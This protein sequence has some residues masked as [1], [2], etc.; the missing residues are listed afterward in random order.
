[1]AFI[2]VKFPGGS[3]VD[4]HM[5]NYIVPTD[6]PVYAGGEGS[7]P[8]PFELFLASIATCAGIYALG[9]CQSKG[10]DT[11]GLAL[12]MDVTKNPE[13]NMIGK[14]SLNLTLPNGFPEKYKAAIIR[15]MDLCAVKKHMLQ[16]P[17][18]EIL[19]E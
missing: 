1:M 19:A 9:F 7:A 11:V 2:E 3:R 5:K 15:S 6:Q 8:A 18:F 10:I 14:V 12:T 4:A 16:P 17:E 13:T